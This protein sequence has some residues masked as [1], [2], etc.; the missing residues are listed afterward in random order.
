MASLTQHNLTLTFALITDGMELALAQPSNK[1][2][3]WLS[4]ISSYL[5]LCILS[6][7][8]SRISRLVFIPFVIKFMSLYIIKPIFRLASLLF[9]CCLYH[10]TII[11]SVMFQTRCEWSQHLLTYLYKCRTWRMIIRRRGAMFGASS[12]IW[13]QTVRWWHFH[14]NREL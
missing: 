11:S 6:C 13:M 14:P 9:A 7:T 8:I 2:L 10:V 12:N 5:V 4:Y 3:C 1:P